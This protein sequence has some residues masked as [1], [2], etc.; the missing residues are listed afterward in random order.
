M[1]RRLLFVL[2]LGSALGAGVVAAP[3]DAAAPV[4]GSCHR[5]DYA[6]AWNDSSDDAAAVPCTTAHTT[7]TVAVVTS[8]T[9]FAGLTTDQLAE[10][11]NT[12][13]DA[14][15]RKALGATVLRVQ[16]A[17]TAW[18]FVPNSTQIAAGESWV[19]CDVALIN[20]SSLQQLPH[21]VLRIPLAKRPITDSIRRCYEGKLETTCNHR[22]TQ[23]AIGAFIATRSFPSVAAFKRAAQRRCPGSTDYG[24][25]TAAAWSAGNHLVVCYKKTRH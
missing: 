23:R 22:H 2:A 20:G 3:A 15:V 6:Q 7:Q 1:I 12:L 24:V 17:Y 13:C 5:L 25:P 10:Q 16:T 21:H 14:P 11:A 19:R 9:P 4:V 8:P 18:D